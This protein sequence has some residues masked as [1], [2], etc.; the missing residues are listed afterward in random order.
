MWCV[1][2]AVVSAVAAVPFLVSEIPVWIQPS[3]VG[4][5]W[6]G[7]FM[8]GFWLGGANQLTGF[9]L[10]MA[11][12]SFGWLTAAFLWITDFT[13]RESLSFGVLILLA[14]WLAIRRNQQTA[15]EHWPD[16]RVQKFRQI[17]LID[18]FLA[19]TVTACLVSGLVHWTSP[20]ALM[21]SVGWAL[22]LGCCL[23]GMATQW[24]WNDRRPV[25]IDLITAF[26]LIAIGVYC[27]KLVAPTLGFREMCQWML[28]GPASV[29]ASQTFSVLLALAVSRRFLPPQQASLSNRSHLG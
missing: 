28:Q 7:Q 6:G 21:L 16:L 4:L 9:R 5:L 3:L 23:C 19:V 17:S 18:L 24:A 29:L 11:S 25:G 27:L 13:F 10:V 15:L 12:A 1:L 26:L 8:L 14:G 22:A 2:L 20:P